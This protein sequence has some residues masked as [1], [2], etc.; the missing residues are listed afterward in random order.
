VARGPGRPPEVA[1]SAAP[2][3][4]PRRCSGGWPRVSRLLRP[5]PGGH[6]GGAPSRRAAAPGHGPGQAGT[7]VALAAGAEWGQEAEADRVN[8]AGRSNSPL[9]ASPELWKGNRWSCLR[10]TSRSAAGPASA[11]ASAPWLPWAWCPRSSVGGEHGCQ[12]ADPSSTAALATSFS[13]ASHTGSRSRSW[14]PGSASGSASSAPPGVARLSPAH[15][16]PPLAPA[17]LR[18]V[19]PPAWPVTRSNAAPSGRRRSLVRR[20]GHGSSIWAA[21]QG[22]EI[23]PGCQPGPDPTPVGLCAGANAARKPQLRQFNRDN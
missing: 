22:R 12:Q 13:E 8:L 1:G 18:L 5:R 21:V 3:A 14:G 2:C 19:R 6:P 9:L 10:I 11:S 7:P 4:T 17:L 15:S 20:R 23:A 16:V